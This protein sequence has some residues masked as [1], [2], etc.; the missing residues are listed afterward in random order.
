MRAGSSWDGPPL[1]V[2]TRGARA[3]LER[4]QPPGQAFPQRGI[5]RGVDV[6]QLVGVGA[7]VV[8]LSL[9]L[10]I[11]HVEMG[12]GS[13]RG[14]GRDPSFVRGPMLDEEVGPPLP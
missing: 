4:G 6:V 5:R 13:E 9:L 2:A 7:E 3:R 1:L 12:I 14:V 8:E 10:G 11:L